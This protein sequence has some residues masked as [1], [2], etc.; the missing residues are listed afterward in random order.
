M[1]TSLLE[2]EQIEAHLLRLSESG[3]ML[4]FEARLLLE[5]ELQDKMIWQQKTYNI[6]RQYGRNQLKQEIE[7][8]HQKLFTE[9]HHQS[10][11]QKII[12][13]FSKK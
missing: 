1:R 7:N 10:F 8:V 9:E 2:T 12:R 6:V 3:D 4:V 11:R 5:P 13:L